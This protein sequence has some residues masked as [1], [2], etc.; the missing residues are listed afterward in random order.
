M[1]AAAAVNHS[2]NSSAASKAGKKKGSMIAATTG[3]LRKS[4][5]NAPT[6]NSVQ[7]NLMNSSA[8]YGHLS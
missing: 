3:P 7:Q 2:V 5:N 4:L 8:N 1:Q 6:A